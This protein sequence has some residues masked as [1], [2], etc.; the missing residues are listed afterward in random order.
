MTPLSDS[1]AVVTF[2]CSIKGYPLEA[3]IKPKNLQF[4]SVQVFWARLPGFA[5]LSLISDPQIS[6][7]LQ[8]GINDPKRLENNIFTM[9]KGY[10]TFS[11]VHTVPI[12]SCCE[13]QYVL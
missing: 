3:R 2:K 5:Q 13:I 6:S 8:N 7:K 4:S 10:E 9:M 12:T 1:Q 11:G